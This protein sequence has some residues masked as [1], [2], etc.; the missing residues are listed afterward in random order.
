MQEDLD[1]DLRD[2]RQLDLE[3]DTLQAMT[4]DCWGLTK[5]PVSVEKNMSE[6][7]LTVKE[8]ARRLGVSLG[9][10]YGLCSRKEIEH[11]RIGAY[12]RGTLRIS[13]EALARYLEKSKSQTP[14]SLEGLKHIK[15]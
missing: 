3:P 11:H 14:V 8:A 10:V 5:R 13:E 6:Q 2:Q 1:R 15:V 12:G 4:E 9:T 7:L